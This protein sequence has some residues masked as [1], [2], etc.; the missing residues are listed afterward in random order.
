VPTL[1]TGWGVDTDVQNGVPEYDIVAEGSVAIVTD[2][3]AVTAEHTPEAAI[4]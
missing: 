4:V 3:V 2:A 1:V